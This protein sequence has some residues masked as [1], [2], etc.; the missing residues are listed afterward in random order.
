M[1]SHLPLHAHFLPCDFGQVAWVTVLAF[2]HKSEALVRSSGLSVGGRPCTRYPV[3]AF[4]FTVMC[5]KGEVASTSNFTDTSKHGTRT[6][7][8]CDCGG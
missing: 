6:S 2:P 4:M 5:R 7:V 8:K 1:L 3:V